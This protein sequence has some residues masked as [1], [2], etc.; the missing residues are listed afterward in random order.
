MSDSDYV[1]ADEKLEKMEK[2]LHKYS[3]YISDQQAVIEQLQSSLKAQKDE[4]KAKYQELEEVNKHHQATIR[5]LQI[6]LHNV[7]EQQVTETDNNTME[8]DFPPLNAQKTKKRPASPETNDSVSQRQK[9]KSQ[10]VS[11][12]IVNNSVQNSSP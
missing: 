11:T 5:K 4:F 12:S 2:T 3:K 7:P 8:E 1:D 10:P 9:Q 6:K